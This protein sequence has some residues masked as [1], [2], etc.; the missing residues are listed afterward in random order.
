M[1]PPQVQAHLN[2][3]A[4]RGQPRAPA[5]DPRYPAAEAPAQATGDQAP[6]NRRRIAEQL[7]I[8]FATSARSV[9]VA[10]RRHAVTAADLSTAAATPEH[11][12]VGHVFGMDLALSG[13][14]LDQKPSG[15]GRIGAGKPLPDRLQPRSARALGLGHGDRGGRARGDRQVR[16]PLMRGDGLSQ[17]QAGVVE[18]LRLDH[19]LSLS[20][21]R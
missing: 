12:V 18:P 2:Q 20:G 7:E 15:Q 1:Q 9:G 14:Q 19:T 16:L 13:E 3:R 11:E 6:C 17:P 8:D 4:Q 5:T 21:R 10:D